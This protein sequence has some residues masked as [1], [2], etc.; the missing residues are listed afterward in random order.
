MIV[1]NE[2]GRDGQEMLERVEAAT[3][4]RVQGCALRGVRENLEDCW[5]ATHR[6][7]QDGEQLAVVIADGVG[8]LAGGELAS[9][10]A[11]RVLAGTMVGDISSLQARFAEAQLEISDLLGPA[12]TAV[13][14]LVHGD[15]VTI[16]W[17]GDS[18]A[19]LL[20]GSTSGLRQ[21]T[22]D[23]VGLS[24]TP[25]G[26]QREVITR[27]LGHGG[28]GVPQ[29]VE[30]ALGPSDRIVLTTDGVHGCLSEDEIAQALHEGG[31]DAARRVS[32]LAVE[33]GSM[34]NATCVVLSPIAAPS[35]IAVPSWHDADRTRE[36]GVPA[37]A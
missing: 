32:E 27:W 30:C 15:R 21:L 19:W 9:G 7:G 6:L 8:G 5:A 37:L 28:E 1:A 36:L 34:D 31:D 26:R 2:L 16:A 33:L 17:V 3:R 25:D 35:R 12:T 29:I 18:R 11:C 24:T 10:A 4:W 22:E 14:A 20:D 13:L 23:H